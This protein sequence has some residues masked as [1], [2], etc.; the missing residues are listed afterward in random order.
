MKNG[1]QVDS[2]YSDVECRDESGFT[3]L[4]VLVVVGLLAGLSMLML[5]M[6]NQLRPLLAVRDK[7]D[8]VV[9]VEALASYV[10]SVISAS[11]SIPVLQADPQQRLMMSGASDTI[12]FAA[13]VPIGSASSGLRDVRIY[14]DKISLNGA[15]LMQAQAARR[16]A[17]E[18]KPDVIELAQ[19]DDLQ[20]QYWRESPAGWVKEWSELG[21]LPGAVS[22]GLSLT[23]SGQKVSAV[24]T[25]ILPAAQP[26]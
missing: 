22:F 12:M 17:Q 14:A 19:V 20:F 11:R 25:V 13:V 10:A 16:P 3:L 4:E 24:R 26:H 5:G 2:P 6:I 7:N 15:R 23:R 9:E 1:N 18:Y 21:R 8:A